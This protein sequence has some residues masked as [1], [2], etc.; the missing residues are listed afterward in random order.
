[1]FSW[2][3]ILT[4]IAYIGLMALRMGGLGNL[5][6]RLYQRTSLNDSVAN[7]LVLLSFAS[8]VFSV[9]GFCFARG[10]RSTSAKLLSYVSVLVCLVEMFMSGGRS[11]V[12]LFVLALFYV[13]L[14]RMSLA[15][16]TIAAAI[17]A[18][19]MAGTSYFMTNARFEAQHAAVLKD[20]ADE[21]FISRATTGLQFI[22]RIAA[23]IAYVEQRGHDFGETYVNVLLLPIPRD[24]WPDK[25]YQISN[26]LR[27]FL[28]GDLTGG[29]PPGLFGEGYIGFGT[30]GVVGA[31]MVLGWMIGRINSTTVV[32]KRTGCRAREACAGVLAPLI[33]YA[34]VRGGFDI[35]GLRVGV[36][37]FWCW[38]SIK[39]ADQLLARQAVRA[40]HRRKRRPYSPAE[41]RQQPNLAAIAH[42]TGSDLS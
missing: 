11:N 4:S 3:A 21:S 37:A 26:R 25:P 13:S 23:S 8:M 19:L 22:D 14:T 10:G 20:R 27:Q 7:Y 40:N 39:I 35:A 34:V 29:E 9:F 38:V 6:I 42:K 1:V 16:F 33:A 12:I 30:I 24:L 31:A 41:G 28:F 15:R 5:I 18:V 36:P 2:L 32:A 17:A